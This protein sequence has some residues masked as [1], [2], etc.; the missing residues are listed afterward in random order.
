MDAKKYYLKENVY[1]EPLIN[2]WYA[3]PNLIPPFQYAMYMTR[4]HMRLMKSFIKNYKLHILGNQNKTM[5]GGGEFVDLSETHVQDVQRLLDDLESQR[6]FIE[7][8]EAIE[9]LNGLSIE[10]TDGTSLEVLYEQVPEPLKGFV[11]L[12]MDAYHNPGFR[13][14]EGL[15][16]NSSYY[17]TGLQTVSLGLLEDDTKRP[18]VLSTPRLPDDKHLHIK[19]PFASKF[20]DKLFSART[21]PLS[22][23]EIELLFG[24]S[25]NI[26]QLDKMSLF[27]TDKPVIHDRIAESEGGVRIT[28]TGHAGLIIETDKVSILVDPVISSVNSENRGISFSFADLPDTIDYV[29]IT[30]NHSDHVHIETLLQI[31][32][33]IKNVLVPKNNGGSLLDPSLKLIL[34]QLGFN[35]REMDDME[36]IQVADGI[37]TSVPFLGEHGDLNIRSKTGWFFNL[38]DKR[39]YAGADSANL[40]PRMYRHIHQITGDLDVMA[41]GMECV[42]APFTWLYGAMITEKVSN[43]IKQSRRLNGVD[44]RTAIQML[45]I[46][47]AKKVLI[48]A[49]GLETWLGYFMGLDYQDDSE[50]IVQS[51]QFLDHCKGLD[52]P[53]KRLM[54]KYEV[55]I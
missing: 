31:R 20:W 55:N 19:Q 30:H 44:C 39:I 24:D 40:E 18:F 49:L 26:G 32:H 5:A 22:L 10:H 15:I 47:K 17:D 4:T 12:N 21:N 7:I 37:I 29:C 11:E 14:I 13:L 41:I 8:S 34:T 1:V 9:E 16:Y 48:Y 38:L 25:S 46:F 43:K 6:H 35:V 23:E 27:T 54:G 3:W 50:Q 51:S 53:A 33:K 28:Y 45:E 52:I 36:N 2:N 42:G